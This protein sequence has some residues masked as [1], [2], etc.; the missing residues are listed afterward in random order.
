[1]ARFTPLARAARTR[2]ARTAAV[3]L[4]AA[5]IGAGAVVAVDAVD[6]GTGGPVTTTVSATTAPAPARTSVAYSGT[7]MDFS[8]IYAQRSAGVVS[9]LAAAS[10]TGGTPSSPFAPEPRG[11]RATAQG[12]G[13]VIDADGHILTNE[14]VVSGADSLRVTFSS[15]RSVEAAVVGTDP[16]TD[17]ALLKVD[18]PSS[19]LTVVPIGRSSELQV[20]EPVLAIGNPFGYMGSAT[21]GIVS[22]L[23]R[24]ITSPNGFSVPDAIQTD[25][26]VN[27]G[28][29][30]GALLNTRGELIGIPTQIADS[31]VNANVGVAFAVPS[32]TASR[33]IGELRSGG[34]VEHAW[35]GVSSASVD[36]KLRGVEG[37]GAERGALI[38]GVAENGPA[39]RAGLAYGD[40]PA[41]SLAG[42][43]CTGGDV[44]VA[45]DGEE[46]ADAAALQRLIDAHRPG[47]TVRLTVVDARG[48]ERTVEVT[49]AERP[50]T[51]PETLTGCAG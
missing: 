43:V 8:G 28:N 6:G 21:A 18:V 33:V 12:S 16:S 50:A 34:Q 4:A 46:V 49:L 31:G 51:A 37:I 44:V 1:M 24:S 25:A 3:A 29:S 7:Q 5:A 41:D 19:E 23:G 36:E 35:L 22:A 40:T 11:G 39:A 14:H 42:P 20:G 9:I 26:A 32:D 30:G 17:L 45:V 10:G 27:H 15:G 48:K 38:T 2:T 47:D 13:V